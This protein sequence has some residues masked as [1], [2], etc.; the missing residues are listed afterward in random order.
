[1][2]RAH[3]ETFQRTGEIADGV[4]AEIAASWRRSATA[5]LA[6]GLT[7]AP[8]HESVLRLGDSGPIRRRFLS[9]CSELADELSAELGDAAATVV[10][11]DDFGMVVHRAG[12]P[13]ALRAGERVNLIPGGSWSEASVGTT[14]IGLALAVGGLAHVDGAEHYAEVLHDFSCAAAVVRN[15][16]SHEALGVPPRSSPTRASR[17]TFTRPLIDRTTAEAQ[18]RLQSRSVGR[19]RGADGAPPAQH[20]RPGG[21][22]DHR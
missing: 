21:A 16:T 18:R 12:S 8:V 22:P 20:G 15:P 9:V 6:P 1:M 7:A 10:I 11:C 4:R 14:G 19:E 3:W 13:A 5:G 2:L 17:A